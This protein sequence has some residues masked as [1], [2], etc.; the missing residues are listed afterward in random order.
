VSLVSG[1]YL[2]WPHGPRWRHAF[3]WKPRAGPK[4]L[5]Y[6]VHKITGCYGVVL[7][8]VVI[9]TGACLEVPGWVEPVVALVSPLEPMPEPR[10]A[11]GAGSRQVTLDAAAAIAR[12]RFPQARVRWIETPD[13][14]RGVYRIRLYQRGEPSERFPRTFVW[15]DPHD[16]RVLAARDARQRRSGA[17]FLAWLHPLHSGQALG[18]AGRWLVLLSGLLPAA[19]FATGVIRW[20][21]KRQARRVVHGRRRG[22]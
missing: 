4:R 7:L 1:L 3:V 18:L 13:G 22:V 10:A 6:D 16:G 12:D 5:N 14:D 11:A 8:T 15:V 9:V 2:W 19:L 17:A 20:R 21:Q